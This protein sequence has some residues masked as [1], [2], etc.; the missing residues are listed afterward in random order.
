[1]GAVASDANSTGKRWLVLR[2][3]ASPAPSPANALL[4]H[5]FMAKRLFPSNSYPMRH[6]RHKTALNGRI[7]GWGLEGL[8]SVQEV[9]KQKS[10]LTGLVIKPLILLVRRA[11]LEPATF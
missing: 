3:C 6:F 9:S 8:Q 2:P 4:N 10:L 1:M 7:S 11:G 5:D